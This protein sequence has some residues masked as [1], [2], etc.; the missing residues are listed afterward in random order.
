[1]MPPLRFPWFM[2]QRPQAGSESEPT[3]S[4]AANLAESLKHPPVGPLRALREV[5]LAPPSEKGDAG[6]SPTELLSYGI[7]VCPNDMMNAVITGLVNPI[8][9]IG[10]GISP[11]LIGIML[12]VRGIC[13]AFMDPAMGYITDN[14]TNRWGRRRPYILVGG[15]LMSLI[16]AVLWTLPHGWSEMGYIWLFGTMLILFAAAHSVFS[17]PYYALGIELS[18]HYHGRTRVVLYRDFCSKV[19]SLILPWFLPFCLLS[20]FHDS[21]NGVF[22]LASMIS[23]IGIAASILVAAATKERPGLQKHQRE[24]FFAAFFGTIKSIHFLKITAVYVIMLFLLGVFQIFGLYLNL[25]YVFQGDIARGATY[26][27]VLGTFGAALTLL[28]MPLAGWLS[29]RYEKHNALRIALLLMTIGSLLN[30]VCINPRYPALLFIVPFFYSLGITCTFTILGSL[31]ADVVDVDELRSSRR[32]E[33]M[34]G[35]AASYFMKAANALAAA[36]SGFAL[37]GTGFNVKLGGHQASG[38]FS[39]MLILY[40]IAPA[41]L[42]M[43]CFGL[44]HR[45]PITEKFI[46]GI[47]PELER[48]RQRQ[49][50]VISP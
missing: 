31:M 32:R 23:V 50:E 44:L 46:E 48:L 3:D 27:A 10:L 11:G 42:L 25:Y 5:F 15:I 9:N 33:G 36:V 39:S 35:A 21:I 37:E 28:S 19:I 6:A 4:D 47:R 18:S 16:F 24:S 22:W 41:F 1:M 29:R 13:D 26:S 49:R 2:T 14:S 34:F 45:Y 38:T 12:S 8:L 30:L 40:S 7:G 17:V 20:I 43:I